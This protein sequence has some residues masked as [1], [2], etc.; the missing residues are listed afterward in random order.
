MDRLTV[1][2]RRLQNVLTFRF[3]DSTNTPRS[4]VKTKPYL[5]RCAFSPRLRKPSSFLTRKSRRACASGPQALADFTAEGGEKNDYPEERPAPRRLSGG[6]AQRSR[7]AADII[8]LLFSL[9]VCVVVLFVSSS[10]SC[11]SR[12]ALRSL[13]AFCSFTATT[14]SALATPV[15]ARHRVEDLCDTCGW[16]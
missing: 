14:V 4:Y 8:Q 12:S 11:S 2:A 1:T 5:L 9:F 13:S 6:S 16:V 7:S 3:T 15:H 10:S